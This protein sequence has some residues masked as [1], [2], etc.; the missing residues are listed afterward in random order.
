M[1]PRQFFHDDLVHVTRQCAG[2]LARLRPSPGV[3]QVV[4]YCLARAARRHGLEVIAFAVMSTHVHLVMRDPKR[5][6]P[7]FCQ[8]LFS[9]IARALN[10]MTADKLGAKVSDEYRA[11]LRRSLLASR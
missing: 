1:L 2:Q 10:V 3:T 9:N 11:K 8:E 5:R 7:F 4:T 6:L